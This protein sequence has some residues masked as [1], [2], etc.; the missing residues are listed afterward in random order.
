MRKHSLLFLVVVASQMGATK[1]GQVLR[2]PGFDLWCG[3]NLCAWKLERGEVKR[4]ATWNEGDAGVELVGGDVAI[5]QLT[6]VNSNDGTCIRFDLV[7]NVDET[8]EVYLNV[9]V[10]GDGTLEMHERI[11]TSHWKPLSYN[12]A[13]TAPYDGI[14][15]E[16][17]KK[18]AGKAVLANIGAETAQN[19]CIDLTP[20]DPGPRRAGAMCT[21]GSQCASGLCGASPV[22]VP[23]DGW[24]ALVCLGCNINTCG[25]NETCGLGDAFSPVF[26]VPVECVA[27]GAKELGEKALGP[28]ECAS[29]IINASGTC[30]AC[31]ASA[32]CASG[33]CHAA[34][35]GGPDVCGPAPSGG[36]CGAD[37]DCLSG[38]CNGTVRSECDDQRPC[39]TPAACPF[40]T[41]ETALQ[42]GACT[43]VGI[44]GGSCQ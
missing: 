27:K 11:P 23:N 5:E 25:T 31:G 14:R 37:T 2:D 3:E 6:P 30:S 24:F 12:F 22:P 35:Q 34:W 32:P 39:T 21:E 42:N 16:I 28:A 33:T 43:T 19:Q 36:P 26:A 20:L 29:G 17:T 10:Q 18:G 7:A 38:H 40:G 8:A 44:Q 4:V 15:F 41:G 1:C 13:V 9:D